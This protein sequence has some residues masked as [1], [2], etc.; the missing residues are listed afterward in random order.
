L[1]KGDVPVASA[2]P[3]AVAAG[4][5]AALAQVMR[6]IVTWTAPKV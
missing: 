6:D 1:F 2:D 5:D 4:L 3:T